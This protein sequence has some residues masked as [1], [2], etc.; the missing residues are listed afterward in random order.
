MKNSVF[1][2]LAF[3]AII[4]GASAL[5]LRQSPHDRLTMQ[6]VA[7]DWAM[8]EDGAASDWSIAPAHARLW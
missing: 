3:T 6:Q 5:A 7:A 2:A 8:T 4:W 1:V